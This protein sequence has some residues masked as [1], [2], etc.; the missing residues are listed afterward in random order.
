MTAAVN[1]AVQENAVQLAIKNTSTELSELKVLV[2]RLL[3]K[4][5][6][7]HKEIK[8]GQTDHPASSTAIPVNKASRQSDHNDADGS[9]LS[10][11][12]EL[13]ACIIDLRST[14]LLESTPAFIEL[15]H[16]VPGPGSHLLEVIPEPAIV[17]LVNGNADQVL[18]TIDG[19]TYAVQSSHD[20]GGSFMMLSFVMHTANNE[21]VVNE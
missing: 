17:E 21:G 5:C 13:P 14:Q 20:P 2:D 3:F 15:F 11:P 8:S 9:S 1:I 4:A 10:L 12:G 19:Q 16:G 18:V 7:D 6:G